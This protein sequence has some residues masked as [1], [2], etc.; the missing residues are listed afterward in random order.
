[1]YLN[2]INLLNQYTDEPSLNYK[3]SAQRRGLLKEFVQM[4]NNSYLTL[5]NSQKDNFHNFIENENSVD[6]L[7]AILKN[8]ELPEINWRY[9]ILKESYV[10]EGLMRDTNYLFCLYIS[11]SNLKFYLLRDSSINI[12]ENYEYPMTGDLVEDIVNEFQVSFF[13]KRDSF[14]LNEIRVTDDFFHNIYINL[15][16]FLKQYINNTN[17]VEKYIDAQKNTGHQNWFNKNGEL[18]AS[19]SDIYNRGNFFTKDIEDI[20]IFNNKYFDLYKNDRSEEILMFICHK[21]LA[22]ARSFTSRIDLSEEENKILCEGVLK[23]FVRSAEKFDTS[24]EAAFSTYANFW[25]LQA[26][27]RNLA[28]IIR[29]RCKEKYKVIPTYKNIEERRRELKNKL[30][31]TP[32][33]DEI[34]SSFAKELNKLNKL[35]IKKKEQ[36]IEEKFLSSAPLRLLKKLDITVDYKQTN[37]IQDNLNNLNYLAKEGLSEQEYGILTSRY[38]LNFSDKF[39]Q[40]MAP[41]EDIGKIHNVT[42]ERIRQIEK[43][44]ISKLK[45]L[46]SVDWIQDSYKNDLKIFCQSYKANYKN[47]TEG[48]PKLYRYFLNQ[49]IFFK[50]QILQKDETWLKKI[51]SELKINNLTS[52]KY[53]N[54]IFEQKNNEL[55]QVESLLTQSIDVL[56]LSYNSHNGLIEER[57]YS[58][59]ALLNFGLGNLVNIKNLNSDSIVEIQKKAREFVKISENEKYFTQD[60]LTIDDFNF[61][62][63][64]LNVFEQSDISS[65]E[66]L[67]K[68]SEE[69]LYYLPNLGT[70]SI[71]EII[72]KLAKQNLKL[73]N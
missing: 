1:M 59:G 58:I 65:V 41:L 5:K 11:S 60:N 71:T 4:F 15:I 2:K 21:N 31:K 14:I 7:I 23:S 45:V 46:E 72:N 19:V 40:S 61:S 66:D 44:A 36:K 63:R 6:D 55:K 17:D 34:V 22:L 52:K 29:K 43:I 57:L 67:L 56:N 37:V 8:R 9:R 62:I 16:D 12:F 54:F 28:I 38:K 10:I 53:I 51:L 50:G 64:I 20:K 49:D 30:G 48:L 69:D 39:D 42:R 32:N 70:T 35:N 24:S 27:S 73:T 3:Q 26:Y 47:R 25:L 13:S 33:I 68:L 18:L